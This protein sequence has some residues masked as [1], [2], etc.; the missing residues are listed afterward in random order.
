MSYIGNN[1]DV[2]AFTVSVERFSGTGSCT[3]FQLTRTNYSDNA[4]IE[5]V[6]SGAQQNPTANYGVENGLITFTS[7]PGVG[8]N[9]IVVTYRAPVVVTFN[10]VTTSQLQANAVT[11]TAIASNA[12]TTIKIAQS[13][14]TG[15]K[16]PDRAIT[17]NN[18]V[19]GS[20]TSNL[21]ATNTVAGNNIV[22]GTITGNLI[23]SGTIAGNA[24]GVGQITGNLI[25]DF[26]ISANNLTNPD[27]FEDTFLLGGM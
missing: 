6:I 23:A 12:V 3:Q 7:A 8:S 14:V 1:P 15:D 19:E 22:P 24:I 16:I 13:A 5:V 27:N 26:A 20:I 9:N 18:I 10:Q 25:A 11:S 17:S 4:A 21:I 2:N